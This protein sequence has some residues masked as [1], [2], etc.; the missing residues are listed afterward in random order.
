M[1]AQSHARDF[2][3][4]SRRGNDALDGMSVRTAWQSLA[5]ANNAAFKPGDRLLL[6]PQGTA[7]QPV[8]IWGWAEPQRIRY[9]WSAY[10]VADLK[11]V[12]GLPVSGFRSD[13]PKPMK[14]IKTTDEE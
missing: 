10:P 7:G 8:S 3:L 12:N 4:D 9:A 2:Y 1:L 5:R 13:R 14:M 6:K 11:D